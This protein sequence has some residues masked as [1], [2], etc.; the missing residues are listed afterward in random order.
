ML[1]QPRQGTWSRT[2][3]KWP[4]TYQVITQASLRQS[5]GCTPPSYDLSS[6]YV[7]SNGWGIKGWLLRKSSIRQAVFALVI[8]S[9]VLENFYSCGFFSHPV[10]SWCK[11]EA[12]LLGTSSRNPP[13]LNTN[14]NPPRAS[15]NKS[16]SFIWSVGCQPPVQIEKPSPLRNRRQNRDQYRHC[17][18]PTRYV[19]SMGGRF[20]KAQSCHFIC[21]FGR[22]LIMRENRSTVNNTQCVMLTILCTVSDVGEHGC[23]LRNYHRQCQWIWR[24]QTRRRP[25]A[26][27]KY[28]NSRP[29]R[30]LLTWCTIDLSMLR[31]ESKKSG[32]LRLG[33]L[34]CQLCRS[35]RMTRAYRE[36]I[37]VSCSAFEWGYFTIDNR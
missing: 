33:H 10:D 12:R 23:L 16:L 28:S 21:G 6:W 13:A 22:K 17:D 36:G 11:A 25:V 26:T 20:G 18:L 19:T 15:S 29:G 27:E 8:C 9:T 5:L 7:V 34:F 3:G 32:W 30:K 37:P 4:E 31:A 1:P 35:G 14:T 24:T 2:T